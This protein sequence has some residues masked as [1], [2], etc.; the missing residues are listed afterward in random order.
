MVQIFKNLPIG[1]WGY[2]P[3]DFWTEDESK[4]KTRYRLIEKMAG[5][6]QIIGRR[7]FTAN[8]IP[9]KTDWTPNELYSHHCQKINSLS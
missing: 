8:A 9:K 7:T 3:I 5:S 6:F 2:A 1:M 4:T